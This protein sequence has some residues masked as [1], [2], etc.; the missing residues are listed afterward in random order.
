MDLTDNQIE[1]LLNTLGNMNQY[2]MKVILCKV[3]NDDELDNICEELT[4][5][6]LKLSKE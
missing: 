1:I 4:K 3:Y 2:E 5:I 6:Y